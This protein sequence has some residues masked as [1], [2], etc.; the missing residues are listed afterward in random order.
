MKMKVLSL[1]A[2]SAFAPLAF[3]QLT[4]APPA[5]AGTCADPYTDL[6]NVTFTGGST[7]GGEIGINMGGAVLPHPSV[8][9]TFTYQDDSGA[10]NEPDQIQVTGS[11]MNAIVATS[12]TTAPVGGAAVG[13]PFDM[14]ATL[15]DGQTYFVAVTT[16]PSVPVT[17]PPTC[18]DYTMANDTLP[19]ELQKASVE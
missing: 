5:G 12:C 10:G 18:A 7:C 16:D 11:N 19:V 15:V 17:D 8:V 6:S 9:F 13:I 2:L 14:D 1:L 4:P 3:A